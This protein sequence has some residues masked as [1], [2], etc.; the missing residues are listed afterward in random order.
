[1]STG[2]GNNKS[3]MTDDFSCHIGFGMLEF[4]NNTLVPSLRKTLSLPHWQKIMMR[5]RVV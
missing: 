1:M 5:V 3:F 2:H 4:K